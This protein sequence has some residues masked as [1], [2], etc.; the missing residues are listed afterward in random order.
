M[1]EVKLSK[2]GKVTLVSDG[3]YER[4]NQYNWCV[5]VS[6]SGR[7]VYAHRKVNGKMVKLH[8]FIMGVL[9]NPTPH[10]DHINGDGLDNRKCNLRFATA[11]QNQHNRN[12]TTSYRGKPA[13]SR[14][15]GVHWNK[16]RRKW[17]ARAGKDGVGYW[18]GRFD[19]EID[20]ARAYNDF[21]KVHHGEFA[22]LN[23]V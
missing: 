17:V 12:T 18:L 10:I 15:K 20:A 13:S 7:Y 23:P 1:K 19:I 2:S 4:V 8:R 6:G 21:V 3:D 16:S 9:D 5:S 14:F 11:S 22:R